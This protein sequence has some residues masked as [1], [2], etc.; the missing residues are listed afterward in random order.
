MAGRKS[1]LTPEVQER[2]CEAIR[3]QMPYKMAAQR[4]GIDHS[5]LNR[6]L[7]KGEKDPGSIY[8]TF[9]AAVKEAESDGVTELLAII[10]IAAKTHWQAAA[11]LLERRYHSEFGRTLAREPIFDANEEDSG[12]REQMRL[13]IGGKKKTA[14]KTGSGNGSAA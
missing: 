9:R 7:D 10:R 14:S 13:V 2:I 8:G 4:G 5:T 6:W 12:I 3:L 1:K 11:W